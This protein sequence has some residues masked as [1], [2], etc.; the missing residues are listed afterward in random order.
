MSN[1]FPR[2]RRAPPGARTEAGIWATTSR[3][4]GLKRMPIDYLR[5]NLVVTTSGNFSAPAFLCTLFTLGADNV[6]FSVDWPYESNKVA[7]DFLR[8]LPIAEGDRGKVAHLNAERLLG[9]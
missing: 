5:D 9:L 7:I 1:W 6:L 2:T 3:R 8:T 4:S